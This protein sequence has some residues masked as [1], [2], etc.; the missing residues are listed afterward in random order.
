MHGW[1]PVNHVVGRYTGITQCPGCSAQDETIDHL[2]HCPH[3]QMVKA[4]EESMSNLR[5]FLIR[6]GTS[7]A[8]SDQ[9]ALF[10]Q[11]YLENRAPH[12]DNHLAQETYQ[13]QMSIGHNL[14]LRGYL[15]IEWLH[16]LRHSGHERPETVLPNLIF[17]LW[18]EFFKR[19]WE[20]RNTLLH[21]SQNK[22]TTAL[23]A[24]LDDQLQWYLAHRRYALSSTDQRLITFTKDDLPSMP[25]GTKKEWIRQL[26]AVKRTWAMERLQRQKGQTIITNF[27]SSNHISEEIMAS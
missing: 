24:S 18:H 13:S 6:A 14:I 3:Q 19:I 26:D 5:R 20:A 27:F 10:I 12:T 9:F 8:F 22:T 7:R 17:H 11:S 15:S 2:F 16:L 21:R 25:I 1:L 4:R 23:E